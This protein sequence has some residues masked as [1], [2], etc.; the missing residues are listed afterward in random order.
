MEEKL[1]K[2]IEESDAEVKYTEI[3]AMP[4][5]LGTI[6]VEMADQVVSSD[7]PSKALKVY[8][9]TIILCCLSIYSH[10]PICVCL[11]NRMKFSRFWLH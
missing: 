8:V 4:R 7:D 10:V 11:C 6:F 5:V 3:H 9:I 2:K 1:L